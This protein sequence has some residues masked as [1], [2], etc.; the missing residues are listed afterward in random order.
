[1]RHE[2]EARL[3]N[4]GHNLGRAGR[5]QWFEEFVVLG[6]HEHGHVRSKSAHGTHDA[7]GRRGLVERKD[8]DGG[9]LET[10]GAQHVG[11]R[12]IAVD[13]GFARHACVADAERVEIER[14]ELEAAPFE[15]ASEVLSDAAEAA[16]HHVL[17][18]GD[19]PRCHGLEREIGR[20]GRWAAQDLSAM[21]PL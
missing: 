17:A 19:F 9:M 13:H 5:L 15:H 11:M 8:D 7:Q 4:A 21:R 3:K 18:L 2:R 1:M 14:D 10:E 20:L 6:A 12:G 16:D